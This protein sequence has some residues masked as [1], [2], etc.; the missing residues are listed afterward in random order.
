MD[1]SDS[2]VLTAAYRIIRRVS[3]PED[4]PFP[5]RLAG[6]P[7]GATVLLVDTA[8]LPPAWAGWAADPH[9]LL[10]GVEDVVRRPDGHDA[11]VS[12]FATRLAA[13][14]ARRE[15]EHG[16]L[17]AGES[18]TVGV[19]LLRALVDLGEQD[20]AFPGEWWLTDA[21]RPV[22]VAGVGTQDAS[23]AT[24][25]VLR[26]LT[27]GWGDAPPSRAVAPVLASAPP[28]RRD[29]DDAED[30]LFAW[31]QAAPLRL[32]G[33]PPAA[34][35]IGRSEAPRGLDDA[36][37][38]SPWW[39]RLAR[40]AD[41]DVADLVA[42]AWHDLTTRTRTR[43]RAPRGA[44][45]RRP[46]LVGAVLA[47]LLVAGGALWPAAGGDDA[48]APAIAEPTASAAA[49]PTIAPPVTAPVAETADTGVPG[50]YLVDVL[51]E[52]LAARHACAGD[53]VCLS[54][55]TLDPD[56]VMVEGAIDLPPSE[57]TI[58]LIDDFGG[59]AVLGVEP[60]TG[61]GPR[62]I[63]VIETVDRRWLLRDVHEAQQ[64]SG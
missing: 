3:A 11:V 13:L 14:L 49:S 24:R 29:A 39:H 38:A 32:D 47:G 17:D 30:A 21:G 35:A 54:E 9:S 41:R 63:V 20:D 37:L 43:R 1:V 10:L 44:T 46:W 56:R 36:P 22:L 26:R 2:T 5:G 48:A 31:A 7:G 45:R 18:V 15:G 53:R 23:A 8:D 62:Q 25:E 42:G 33:R 4:A 27:E 52:L 59:V 58:S 12:P 61:E 51:G 57:R 40:H 19:C 16:G 64:P 60:L 50:S 28:S 55:V 6:D 34:G